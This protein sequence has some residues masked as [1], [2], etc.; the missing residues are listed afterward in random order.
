MDSSGVNPT[1]HLEAELRTH[2]VALL[3]VDLDFI[4]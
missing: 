4:L 2:S 3:G 1:E